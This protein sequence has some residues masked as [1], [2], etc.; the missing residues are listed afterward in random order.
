MSVDK[1]YLDLALRVLGRLQSAHG[2]DPSKGHLTLDCWE[3]PSGVALYCIHK[4]YCKTKDP[5]IL[6][7]LINWYDRWLPDQPT[8]NVNTA[9]PLLALTCLYETTRDEK[10][11]PHIESWAQW[12]IEEMPRT[13]FS[14]LQHVTTMSANYQQL[15]ADTLFMAGLFLIKAGRTLD[16]P[17]WVEEGLYQF[18][19]HIRYLQDKV[20]GL[21][22]HGWTFD[23]RHNFANAFW[24]R[25][26]SWFTAAGVEVLEMLGTQRASCR[27]IRAALQ[28]QVEALWKLQ[29]QNG[30][31]NTLL[32]FEDSPLETSAT[33]AIAF[34]VIKGV[35]LEFLP[36]K[37]RDMGAKAA[38]AVLERIETDGTV[39]G[40]SGGTGMG[41]TLRHY[42]DIII[43]P[44]AYGQGLA[45]LLLSE[46]M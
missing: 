25:G 16:K 45:F 42:R 27:F 36:E 37:Y 39:T 28:D 30:M 44:T 20:T 8:R 26:N 6:Q 33:A 31:F 12:I 46:M 11:L 29:R 15:W 40:V 13:E 19:L 35:R 43:T 32:D 5:A 21:W 24:A 1:A 17:D 4:T 14:G 9:A 2:D 41:N 10:Y 18:L 7:Y 22:Y 34:G 3:W 38:K 23:R